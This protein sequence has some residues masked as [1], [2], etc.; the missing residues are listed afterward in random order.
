MFSEFTKISQGD[1]PRYVAPEGSFGPALK[2][3]LSRR[4]AGCPSRE[5]LIEL[6]QRMDFRDC[7]K[8]LRLQQ[9][10]KPDMTERFERGR[11]E[12]LPRHS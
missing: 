3:S 1:R 4:S 9:F 8:E 11:L 6:L 12:L 5:V 2:C 7:L 10:G